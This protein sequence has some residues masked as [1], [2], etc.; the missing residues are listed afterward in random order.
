MGSHSAR[1]IGLSDSILRAKSALP[2]LG[3]STGYVT[4]HNHVPHA[5][6]RKHRSRLRP[7]PA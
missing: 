3:L 6:G 5:A 7:H 4:D 1:A 2:D